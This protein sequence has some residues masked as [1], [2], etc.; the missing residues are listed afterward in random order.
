MLI[1]FIEYWQILRDQSWKGVLWNSSATRLIQVLNYC[2]QFFNNNNLFKFKINLGV[3][4]LFTMWTPS[5]EDHCLI[6]D[7]Q[8]FITDYK[9]LSTKYCTVLYLEFID[10]NTARGIPCYSSDSR[11]KDFFELHDRLFVKFYEFTQLYNKL[12]EYRSF[13]MNPKN[14]VK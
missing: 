9:A 8:L 4:W 11:G 13:K 3:R 6:H 5:C 14:K 10:V 12:T 2:C 1:L 7:K